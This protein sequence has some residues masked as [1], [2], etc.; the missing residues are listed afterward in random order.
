MNKVVHNL[1]IFKKIYREVVRPRKWFVREKGK[2]KSE[3]VNQISEENKSN[4][5]LV[6]HTCYFVHN[7]ITKYK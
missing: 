7:Y 4:F 2:R 3:K 6:S 1:F 5:F